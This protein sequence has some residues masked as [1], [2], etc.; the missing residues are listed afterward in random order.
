[1]QKEA[2][3]QEIDALPE[4]Q[5]KTLWDFVQFLHYM[6]GQKPE[7][8]KISQRIPGLDA[9]TTWV[10]DDFDAPLPDSFWLGDDGNH[11]TIA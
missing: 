8:R 9:G 7:S 1:M 11:E 3:W 10:S 4:A 5:L 2:L 6:S